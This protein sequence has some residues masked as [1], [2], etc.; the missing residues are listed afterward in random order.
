MLAAQCSCLYPSGH[1]GQMLIWRQSSL[2]DPVCRLQLPLPVL[3]GR[4]GVDVC[5]QMCVCV[6]VC[7]CACACVRACA[8]VCVRVCVCANVCCVCGYIYSNNC[9]NDWGRESV[10]R[11]ARALTFKSVCKLGGGERRY[12]KIMCYKTACTCTYMHSL[13]QK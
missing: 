11:C 10:C 13:K 6:C 2:P 8:C 9:G 1:R 5:V 7:V 12:H 3:W 4:E